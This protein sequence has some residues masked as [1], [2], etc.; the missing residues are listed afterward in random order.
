MQILGRFETKM[1]TTVIVLELLG[2][3]SFEDFWT[4]AVCIVAVDR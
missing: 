1:A 4:D 3:I 2:E